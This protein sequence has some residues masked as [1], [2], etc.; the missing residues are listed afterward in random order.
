ME[1]LLDGT[2]SVFLIYEKK[3][4]ADKYLRIIHLWYIMRIKVVGIILLED[5]LKNKSLQNS[6]CTNYL[7]TNWWL[8]TLMS[9]EMVVSITIT[10]KVNL[11]YITK[12][13]PKFIYIDGT[14]IQ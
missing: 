2:D 5:V 13:R 7:A 6:L 1:Y 8:N 10:N 3:K 14:K 12:S 4:N 11:V 9:S